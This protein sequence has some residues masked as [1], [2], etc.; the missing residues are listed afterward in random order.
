LVNSPPAAAY[1]QP[2]SGSSAYWNTG[3]LGSMEYKIGKRSQRLRMLYSPQYSDYHFYHPAWM[4]AEHLSDIL[5][6]S[7]KQ[8]SFSL[9]GGIGLRPTYHAVNYEPLYVFE[10]QHANKAW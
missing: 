6:L 7:Q 5:S 9:E 10:C 2:A 8:Y 4:Q 3:V 1:E